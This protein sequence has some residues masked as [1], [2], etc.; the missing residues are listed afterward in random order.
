MGRKVKDYRCFC[1]WNKRSREGYG[2]CTAV[3]DA[4]HWQMDILIGVAFFLGA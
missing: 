1:A 3:T 2:Y 4:A